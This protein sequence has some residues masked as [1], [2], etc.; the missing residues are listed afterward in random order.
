MAAAGEGWEKQQYN[1][2]TQKPP[3]TATDNRV[4]ITEYKLQVVRT[5]STQLQLLSKW[6]DC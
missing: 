6:P 5:G 3:G 4:N 1:I 2:G